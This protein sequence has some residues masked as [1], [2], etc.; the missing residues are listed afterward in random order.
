MISV[1]SRGLIAAHN[2]EPDAFVVAVAADQSHVFADWPD[3][4]VHRF[5][6]LKSFYFSP[7]PDAEIDFDFTTVGK[8]DT[9]LAAGQDVN[10]AL[11]DFPIMAPLE[12]VVKVLGQLRSDG[13][14]PR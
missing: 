11:A 3:G 12:D 6:V 10:V 1:E 14:A 2:D 9:G 13:A 4:A 5:A 7:V 8:D